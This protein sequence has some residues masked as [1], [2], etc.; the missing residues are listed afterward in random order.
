LKLPTGAHCT[1][2][3]LR[4]G[5]VRSANTHVEKNVPPGRSLMLLFTAR[6]ANMSV[7]CSS[8]ASVQE[9]HNQK[10]HT[11]KATILRPCPFAGAIADATE[12]FSCSAKNC[13][14]VIR[15]FYNWAETQKN[16]IMEK[17]V[18]NMTVSIACNN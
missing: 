15:K 8:C 10:T 2:L 7:G 12:N 5:L 1:P 11:I 17:K 14:S 4:H 3:K 18:G 13:S 16:P 6:S 9:P